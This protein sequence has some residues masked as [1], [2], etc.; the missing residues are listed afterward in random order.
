MSAPT[1]L[2]IAAV[3]ASAV[4]ELWL[5]QRQIAAVEAHREQ[6]PEPFD[7]R[8]PLEA[9]RK[10][11]DYT[12][13]KTRL[14]RLGT[15]LDAGVTLA[16]TVGG[17][18]AAIDA[19]SRESGWSEPWRGL[20]VIAA[21]ACAAALVHLPLSVFRTFRLEARFGFN[22]TTPA[23]FLADLAKGLALTGL[24]GGALA[25][26]VLELMIHARAW[27]LWAFL[28]WLGF[29]LLMTWAWP[30]LIAPLFNR[31]TPLEDRSLRERI[32]SLLERCGFRSSGVF[33]IDGSRRS[34]HGNA[35]FS[36]IGRHKRIVFFDTL[37]KE[38]EGEEIEAVLAHELGHFRLHH[39]RRRLMVSALIGLGA[40]ALLGWLAAQPEF[41]FV[42]GVT[43]PSPHAALLLFAL[44][45]PVALAFFSPLGSLW[46]RHDE[47]AAD[48][49]AARYSS[50]ARLSS[51]LVKLYR[52]NASTLTPDALY[53]AFYYSHPPALERIGHLTGLN[54]TDGATGSSD[55][56]PG[57]SR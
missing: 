4:L 30:A 46:S 28:C 17:G 42:L 11:A 50:A 23:L 21:V 19:L 45:A 2:F 24:L 26:A 48:R 1:A 43:R 31:F 5:A 52:D 36:G 12:L 57:L 22:R 15:L 8:I 53:V 47:L 18:I 6:V 56:A 9:H 44:A 29:T 41:Y 54:R 10:A 32:E 51:A 49:F 38:L 37:L 33:V 34:T 35:Y 3:L 40:F 55:R 16:L 39:V 14:G 27:W 13:A 7:G 25:L 20:A